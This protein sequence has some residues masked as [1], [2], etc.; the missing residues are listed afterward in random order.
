MNISDDD[1]I[2]VSENCYSKFEVDGNVDNVNESE[3]DDENCR[4]NS[5][6]EWQTLKSPYESSILGWGSTLDG[7]LGL[8]GIEEHHILA[9]REVTF[10][11][12]ANIKFGNVLM[13]HIF[14]YNRSYMSI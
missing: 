8:G 6:L 12:S 7:E 11:D 5:S 9:P 3:S 13:D 2:D 1:G 14:Y 10:H 4:F